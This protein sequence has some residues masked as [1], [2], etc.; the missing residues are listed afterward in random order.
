MQKL[1]KLKTLFNFSYLQ[2]FQAKNVPVT[3]I[4]VRIVLKFSRNCEIVA[5]RPKWMQ[6]NFIF[7]FSIIQ[8]L[9]KSTK[10]GCHEEPVFL[11]PQ[12]IEFKVW[13]EWV[14]MQ[15]IDTKPFQQQHEVKQIRICAMVFWRVKQ[16]SWGFTKFSY[17]WWMPSLSGNIEKKISIMEHSKT[18]SGSYWRN[19][20]VSP[21]FNCLGCNKLA[22]NQ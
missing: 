3:K 11:K 5:Q 1:V 17:D 7:N 2:Y 21:Q 22:W 8:N 18:E 4:L 19:N 13:F 14:F 15:N 6:K 20:Q 16:C 9:K 12:Q 10:E